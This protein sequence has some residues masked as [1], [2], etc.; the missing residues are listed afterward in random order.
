MSNRLIEL[1]SFDQVQEY[2]SIILDKN[3]PYLADWKGG[4]TT[5]I[6]SIAI[7]LNIKETIERQNPGKVFSGPN[8]TRLHAIEL[9]NRMSELNV[10]CA[11]AEL[12]FINTLSNKTEF[13]C[14][15]NAFPIINQGMA[16]YNPAIRCFIIDEPKD[17]LDF[18]ELKLEKCTIIW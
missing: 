15:I 9:K 2:A 8:I 13:I 16:Y 3:V 17:G 6:D 1:T 10:M 11:Y 7:F 5:I 14:G 4:A 18:G 12:V